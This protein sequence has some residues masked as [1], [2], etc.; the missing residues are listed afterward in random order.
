M[1]RIITLTTDFGISDPYV[2]AVTETILNINPDA[3][4]VDVSHSVKP[5]AVEQA[6][7]LL[8]CVLPYFRRSSIHV[9]VVDPG[10]GT[11]RRGLALST[12]EGVFVGPDNGVLSPALND[13]EHQSGVDGH[14]S[15]SFRLASKRSRLTNPHFQL[16]PLSDTFHG[17]DVFGP[18]AAHIALGVKPSDLGSRVDEI[19]ALPPFRAIRTDNGRLIGRIIHIDRFGNSITT[20]HT[21]QLS[22]PGVCINI[23]GREIHGLYRSYADGNGLE[24]LI[25]SSGFLEVAVNCGSAAD[26]LGLLLGDSVSVRLT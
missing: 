17:R 3:A 2:A 4:I 10:V 21:D 18:A 5:Q 8:S 13:E 15:L 11:Q 14:A 25:G 24:A 20:I 9:V 22:S 26:T 7:F 23:A 6:A 12:D 19:V 1:N 16:S